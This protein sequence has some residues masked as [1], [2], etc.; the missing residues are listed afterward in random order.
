MCVCGIIYIYIYIY[1]KRDMCGQWLNLL[2]GIPYNVSP[3]ILLL[4]DRY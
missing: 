4:P 2:Q 3:G 1:N